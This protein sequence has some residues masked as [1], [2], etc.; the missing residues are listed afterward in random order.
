MSVS[1]N[2]LKEC[3]GQG[4]SANIE[5]DIRVITDIER[6]ASDLQFKLWALE[7]RWEKRVD[8]LSRRQDING[9]FRQ[10]YDFR[11]ALC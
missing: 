11:A 6:R 4:W 8:K 7:E 3:K 2:Q 9:K 10:D 5:E 1:L